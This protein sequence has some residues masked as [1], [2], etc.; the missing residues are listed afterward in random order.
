MFPLLN[1]TDWSNQLM[2]LMADYESRHKADES[3]QKW[4]IVANG[5]CSPIALKVA[6]SS[7]TNT[8][9]SNAP[10]TNVILSSPPRLPFFL[11]PTDPVKIHKSY[12]TLSGTIGKFFWWY[13][14]RN[15]G[16]FIQKFSERNLVG[17]AK[18]LGDH[19]TPNCIAAAKLNN[20]QSKYSTFAFLAGALQDGCVSSL[21][22]LRGT[23]VKVDFIRGNDVR[24]NR[25]RSWF[26]SRKKKT[27]PPAEGVEVETRTIQQFIKDNGNRGKEVFVDGRISLAWEDAD[28]YAKRVLELISD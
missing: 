6:Q 16:K 12:Q 20:G 5:G 17:D 24:R 13:A 9:T 25:A 8:A 21:K 27:I 26:W 4:V 19:W 23:N 18:S 11:E 14:L 7:V 28:G 2:S 10:V 22:S 3:I 15:K 1:I